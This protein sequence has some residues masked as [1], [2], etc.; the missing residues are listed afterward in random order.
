LT[1][2]AHPTRVILIY[3][4][5]TDKNLPLLQAL[6]EKGPSLSLYTQPN[7]RHE[8]AIF[9]GY[10]MSVGAGVDADWVFQI[11]YA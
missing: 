1:L 5:S 9:R 11:D 3:D 4:G 8:A 2:S 7:A 6:Q 10:R